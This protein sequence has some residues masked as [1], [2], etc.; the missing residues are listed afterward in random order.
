MVN[1]MAEEILF[2][3]E[4]AIE[5]GLNARSIGESIFTQTETLEELK[6]QIKEA[7]SVHF[8]E[9]DKPEIIRL[10]IDKDEV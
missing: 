10:H 6:I 1:T 2:L 4:E 3:V 5:G 7:I 9:N 8:E